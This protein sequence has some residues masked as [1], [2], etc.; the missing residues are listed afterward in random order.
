MNT[1]DSGSAPLEH[2]YLRGAPFPT[3]TQQPGLKAIMRHFNVTSEK[4]ISDSDYPYQ[5]SSSPG[6]KAHFESFRIPY[7]EISGRGPPPT[8]LHGSHLGDVYLDRS[9]TQ[10]AAYGRVA[11][12]TWKRWYDPQPLH[13]REDTIVRHPYFRSRLL[14]C[15]DSQGISWFVVTTVS[16]NQER[17]KLKGL[18]S[19][20]AEKTEE[21]KWREASA[22]IGLSLGEHEEQGS[23][24]HAEVRT[25]TRRFTSPLSLSPPPV[26]GKRKTRSQKDR[27]RSATCPETKRYKALL[28]RSIQQLKDEKAELTQEICALEKHLKSDPPLK[29][30]AEPQQ[31]SEWAGKV[32]EDGIK[33]G[34]KKM[35]PVVREY[36]DLIA[37]LAADGVQLNKERKET[38]QIQILLGKKI[39]EHLKLQELSAAAG[40]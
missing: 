19:A 35:D 17:A 38:D 16:A 11:D 7:C 15:S 28:Q 40:A 31:F 6:K 29:A 33:E 2:P 18:V 25:R 27:E 1:T 5:I 36:W 32:V 8:D 10:Y 34:R 20:E 12:G 4:L 39:S 9:P 37:D 22:L 30:V 26:L 14:W 21:T 3:S 23:A 24:S 13:K